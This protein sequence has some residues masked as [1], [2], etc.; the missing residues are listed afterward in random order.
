M[1]GVM[2][3]DKLQIL[4]NWLDRAAGDNLGRLAR[5]HGA[6][7]FNYHR[8]GQPLDV[9][10]CDHAVFSATQEGFAEQMAFLARHFDVI[11]PSDLAAVAGRTKGRH[12][13]VTFDDGYRD[14]YELA[15][16][17][18]KAQGIGATFFI[19]TTFLDNGGVM[20]WWDE[21]AWMVQRSQ[22]DRLAP[23][24][25]GG[26]SLSLAARDRSETTK[27][28]LN[29]YKRLE[30]ERCAQFM[31]W[32][33]DAT[34]SGRC[35]PE[36]ARL[37]WMTWDMVREMRQGGMTFGGHTM[38]H[39]VLSRFS[40]PQQL[41]E[42]QGC[43]QRLREELGEPMR[44]FAYPVGARNAFNG[45]T[46]KALADVGVEFAFSYYGG[47]NRPGE[48]DPCD[49][50]RVAVESGHD[51]ARFRATAC[52]PSLFGSHDEPLMLRLRN[53]VAEFL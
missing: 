27:A 10:V 16:P 22:R 5:W 34:G 36:E 39:P 9:E 19:T 42:I 53:T 3:M 2:K 50:R 6:L 41:H 11:N 44:W 38:H 12:V 26:G 52:L 32:V 4:A 20:A 23:G 35:P 14:N 1:P 51:R 47:Y 15:Y 24:D 45:D 29:H 18:L 17:V 43:A 25:W 7:I 33:A 28:L 49:M 21:I 13:M 30:G 48:W 46:R 8:I 31:D 40:S 37:T